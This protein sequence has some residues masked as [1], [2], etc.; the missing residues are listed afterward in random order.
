MGMTIPPKHKCP[1]PLGGGS[2]ENKSPTLSWSGGPADAKSYALVLFDTRYMMVH[3]VLWDIPATVHELP[4]GLGT[5]YE[6]MNPMGA[7]QASSMNPDKHSYWGPCTSA[8]SFAGTY[9]YRLY[10]LKEA[11]LTLTESSTAQQAQTAVEAAKLDSVVWKGMP[12]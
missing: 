5:G 3:W 12:E 9:E 4:E 2:G 1:M 8:G 6:L 10:A 11:K 7:H